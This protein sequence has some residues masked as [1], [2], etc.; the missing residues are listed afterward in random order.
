MR[1]CERPGVPTSDVTVFRERISQGVAN[2]DESQLWRI[3]EN[4]EYRLDVCRVTN[5]ARIEY[6]QIIFMSFLTL[7]LF[8]SC[9]MFESVT[10][11]KIHQFL[12]FKSFTIAPC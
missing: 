2:V 10:V 7:L 9:F 6:L 1:I 11:S 8:S 4:F 3:M 12:S 5:G